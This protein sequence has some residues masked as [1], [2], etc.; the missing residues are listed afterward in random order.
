MA[1]LS[2]F[3]ILVLMSPPQPIV[4]VLELMPL[5]TSARRTLLLV[6]AINVVS[7]VV[8]EKWGSGVV[9]RI[10]GRLSLLRKGRRRVRDGKA[11]KAVEGGMR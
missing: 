11:Y 4:V 3:S 9:A 7:S 2:L 10:V 1:T 8:F 6:A 5:P